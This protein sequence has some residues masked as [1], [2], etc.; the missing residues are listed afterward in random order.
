MPHPI[1][2]PPSHQLDSIIITLHLP[3]ARNGRITRMEAQGRS[4]T[5]RASLWSVSE[6]WTRD[7]Q[8]AGLEPSDAVHHLALVALQDHP[9]SQSHLEA[10]LTGQG[11]EQ[12]ELPL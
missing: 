12:L 5:S 9:A 4:S 10:S 2:G 7:E 8:R 6:T 11:W 1:Y 3:T